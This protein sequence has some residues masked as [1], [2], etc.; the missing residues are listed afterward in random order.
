[1][2][3]GL[4]IREALSHAQHLGI[5]KIWIRSDSLSLIRAI[6]SVNK[7]VNL[8]GILSN[9]ESLSSSFVFCCFSFVS[10]D[11]NGQADNLAKACLYNVFSSWV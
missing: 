5:T 6:N 3:E 11:L 10:R 4:A 7:P 2:A 9:I 1:M 8:Y